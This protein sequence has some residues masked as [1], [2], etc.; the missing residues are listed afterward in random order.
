MTDWIFEKAL[1]SNCYMRKCGLK[2]KPA[3]STGKIETN[4]KKEI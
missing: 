3:V 2:K 4:P 1:F